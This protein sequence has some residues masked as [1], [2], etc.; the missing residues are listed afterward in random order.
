VLFL[1]LSMVAMGLLA[2]VLVDRGP[3]PP[4][5]VG[6]GV[7]AG[8]LLVAALVSARRQN[9]PAFPMLF[10]GG[11]AFFAAVGASSAVDGNPDGVTWTGPAVLAAAVAVAGVAAVLLL[12]QRTLTPVVPFPP[13]LII[14]VT[15]AMAVLV[16][17]LLRG[18]ELTVP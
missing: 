17:L 7:L 14:G 1:V 11:A 15:A 18:S 6:G 9:D 16:E 8:G 4:Q 3:V 5:V 2:A 13:F 12:A 10:G